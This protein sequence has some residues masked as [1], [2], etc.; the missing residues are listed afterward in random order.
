M[1]S[2]WWV[3]GAF[4]LGGAAGTL[5][6]V[7]MQLVGGLPEATTPTIDLNRTPG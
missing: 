2:I 5:L 1:V 4:L 3:L 6:M 7:L